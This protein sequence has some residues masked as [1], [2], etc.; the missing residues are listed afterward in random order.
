MNKKPHNFNYAYIHPV[1]AD[2]TF[3]NALNSLD[4][5]LLDVQVFWK[6]PRV[7]LHRRPN[8]FVTWLKNLGASKQAI[9]WLL[10]LCTATTPR[11]LAHLIY[12][13]DLSPIE[14]LGDRS[15]S[16][17]IR[18]LM[19]ERNYSTPTIRQIL[20]DKLGY[21]AKT[22][23]PLVRRIERDWQHEKVKFVANSESEQFNEVT[24]A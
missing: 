23:R 16:S 20:I 21:E 4:N 10:P 14:E 13:R 11:M 19:F 24:F 2:E 6:H 5:M 7:A 1:L 15:V 18:F 3:N 12:G 17:F 8:D 9:K 22:A